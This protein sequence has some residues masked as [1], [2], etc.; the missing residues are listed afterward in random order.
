MKKSTQMIIDLGFNKD[1]SNVVVNKLNEKSTKVNLQ[2][3]E[4]INLSSYYE[5][6]TSETHFT[7]NS[8][9]RINLYEVNKIKSI[10]KLEYKR[11]ATL[12]DEN[13][14]WEQWVEIQKGEQQ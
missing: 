12:V 1:L 13:G 2:I 4:Q 7:I 9:Y 8:P 3:L 6:L 14:L 11:S 5:I 10:L